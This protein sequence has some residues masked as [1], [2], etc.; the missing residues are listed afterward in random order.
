MFGH[1]PVATQLRPQKGHFSP[2]LHLALLFVDQVTALPGQ[3]NTFLNLLLNQ[4]SR[5]FLVDTQ[6]DM[7]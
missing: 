5:R 4:Y 7:S 2:K 3:D 6:D 1:C